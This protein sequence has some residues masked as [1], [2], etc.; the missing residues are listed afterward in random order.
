MLCIT[1]FPIIVIVIR[2]M[3]LEG[4]G[5]IDLIFLLHAG[6]KRLNALKVMLRVFPGNLAAINFSPMR[7]SLLQPDVVQNQLIQHPSCF[8]Q[9]MHQT[10]MNMKRETLICKKGGGW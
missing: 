1:S 10:T 2:V 4:I 8:C 9:R 3:Y 6:M 5:E 7:Y